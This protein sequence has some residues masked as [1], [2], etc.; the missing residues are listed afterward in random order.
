MRKKVFAILVMLACTGCPEGERC[1]MATY[2][3]GCDGERAWTSCSDRY[4]TGME[5]PWA[6]IVRHECEANTVCLDSGEISTCVAE[7]AQA[8]DV[9]D[10]SRCVDGLRQKCRD[11]DAI[12]MRSGVLY[13]YRTGLSC[14][15]TED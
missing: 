14:D 9:V 2:K 10:A 3:A 6:T 7:P 5:K 11:V 12:T 8:C 13:W 1:D 4:H 15:G